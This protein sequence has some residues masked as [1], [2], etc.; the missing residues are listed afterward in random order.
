M[1]SEGQSRGTFAVAIMLPQHID[2]RMRR[3]ST[4][5]PG[6]TWDAS[7]GHVTVTAFHT[8][9]SPDVVAA[10]M[11]GVCSGI[12]PFSA[13]FAAVEIGPYWG[14]PGLNIVM[15]VEGE[16]GPGARGVVR[17]R[18]RLNDGLAKRLDDFELRDEG[19][20]YVP[21][22]TLTTGVPEAET[23]ALADATRAVEID[24]VVSEVALW[25]ESFPAGP[26][27]PYWS[28]FRTIALGSEG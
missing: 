13:H 12:R 11:A 6:S 22:V 19:G 8:A 9:S 28:L 24:F 15:L 7:G 10:E 16:E 5:A 23:E 4:Q 25:H 18:Q 26:S 21:H 2:E 3:W 20:D 1:T 17:L 14:K 27:T